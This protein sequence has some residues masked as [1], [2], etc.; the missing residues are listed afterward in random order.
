MPV[1][2][3]SR[4][5]QKPHRQSLQFF[6]QNGTAL[7]EIL[8]RLGEVS[9]PPGIRDVARM[10]GKIQQTIAFRQ[11]CRTDNTHK[12]P[13]I[14]FVRTQEKVEIL[15]V[16]RRDPPRPVRKHWN[17]MPYQFFPCRWIERIP[18]LLG[19]GGAGIHEYMR[20]SPIIKELR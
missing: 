11:N 7:L 13:D 10:I 6:Q 2:T 4:A 12:I 17:T 19:T 15:H 9:G 3:F 18:Q 1:K 16:G 8:P 20:K 14:G 5:L